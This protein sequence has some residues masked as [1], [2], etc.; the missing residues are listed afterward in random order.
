MSEELGLTIKKKEDFWKWYLEVIKK[1][2]VV[3]IRFKTKGFDVYMPTAVRTIREIDNLF[4]AELESSGHK[5]LMFPNIIPES[6]LI[7]EEKH[8]KGFG[9]EVFWITHAG[10]NKL[11][12]R[13]ALRPTSETAMYPLY[14]IWLRSHLQ[15]PMK[16][17]QQGRVYRYETKMTR[18]LIR[19]REF[20]WFEAHNA[21]KSKQEALEQVKEDMEIF[22]KIVEKACCIPFILIKKPEWDKF[23]GADDTYAFQ[24]ITPD[25]KTLQIGTTHDLGQRFAKAFNIKYTDKDGKKKYVYQT[26]FG[27]GISRILGA[28]IAIHGDDKGLILPPA[29]APVQIVIVP[30]Y[31]AQVNAVVMKKAGELLGSLAEKGFRVDLDDRLQYTPGYKFHEWELKGVPI[32]IEIGPR[33]IEKGEVTIVR[34]DFLE[35]ITVPEDKLQEQLLEIMDS[36][37]FQLLKRAREYL[38]IEDAKNIDEIK[39]IMKKGGF[40][41]IDFCGNEKCAEKIE[42]QT[43]AEVC[44]T[45]FGKQ[46]KIKA[47]CAICNKKAV[48]KV[49]IAITY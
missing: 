23:P 8:I 44:G 28:I 46:E 14:S 33:D 31:T 35:R 27:P 20:R 17:Y 43:G 39:E 19:P 26:C 37:G 32:R 29:I 12:E 42:K 49:Y 15:L 41:R 36:I 5:P 18:P 47:R 16:F 45:L 4:I 6:N 34:R 1:A 30:I 25:G 40:A 38:T 48:E 2:E 3:D 10:K 11:D 22:R 7:T 21:F 9:T 24:T 13:L